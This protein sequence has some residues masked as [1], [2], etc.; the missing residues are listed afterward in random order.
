M[1]FVRSLV[2]I[3]LAAVLMGAARPTAK[4]SNGGFDLAEI[5]EMQLAHGGYEHTLPNAYWASGQGAKIVPVLSDMLMHDT[6]YTDASA[7]P[8]NAIWALGRI[9]TP[10][11]LKALK[12]YQAG[13]HRHDATLAIK[14]CSLRIKLKDKEV[15]VTIR[16]DAQLFASADEKSK[17]L[18][19]LK[20]GTPVRVLHYRAM[21]PDGQLGPTGDTTHFDQV[22][23]LPKGPVGFLERA[24]DDF[25]TIY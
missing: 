25:A 11:A 15:G 2:A 23:L 1:T 19:T 24:G 10:D 16:E 8:F 5:A 9:A 13:K 12:K 21:G 3:T 14:A 22:Q 17:V 4:P 6:K 7:F 18:A 20:P